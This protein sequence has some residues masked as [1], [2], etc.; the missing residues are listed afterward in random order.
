MNITKPEQVLGLQ[1]LSTYMNTIAGKDKSGAFD[2]VM[3]SV[4]DSIENGNTNESLQG[5]LDSM[6]DS[7]GNG[8]GYNIEDLDK[9]Q[10]YESTG[11]YSLD[12][13]KNLSS[14][15]LS[16]AYK[17]LTSSVKGSTAQIN[18]AVSSAARNMV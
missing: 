8:Y 13:L 7:L 17:Q 6:S 14:S 12:S 18:A 10:S 1:L 5:F 3:Q 16:N 4:M 9:L 15:A 11:D 2:L